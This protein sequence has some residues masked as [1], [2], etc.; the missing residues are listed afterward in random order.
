MLKKDDYFFWYLSSSFKS[1]SHLYY[2]YFKLP[3]SSCPIRCSST[4]SPPDSQSPYKYTDKWL[5]PLQLT[6]LSCNRVS[7]S[8]TLSPREGD[9][10]HCYIG[11]HM[12]RITS[13]Q[14]TVYLHPSHSPDDNCRYSYL[15]YFRSPRGYHIYL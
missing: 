6:P 3:I 4:Q 14:C 13:Y 15:L 7:I 9:I 12:G 1:M 10:E 5:Y 8:Q 11:S 2:Y